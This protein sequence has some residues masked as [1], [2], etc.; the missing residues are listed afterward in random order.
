MTLQFENTLAT[1]GSDHLVPASCLE[2]KFWNSQNSVYSDQT[3]QT[4]ASIFCRVRFEISIRRPAAP[5]QI[6]LV[7]VLSV[8]KTD[9]GIS[10]TASFYMFSSSLLTN[11]PSTYN[12]GFLKRI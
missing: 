8:C 12:L 11:Q 1:V 5:T 9:V 6:S 2:T 7:S 3:S 10:T 4:P